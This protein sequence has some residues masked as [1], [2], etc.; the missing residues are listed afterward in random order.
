L[1]TYIP[2]S[3]LRASPSPPPGVPLAFPFFLF[4]F[5]LSTLQHITNY[6]LVYQLP[7][8]LRSFSKPTHSLYFTTHSFPS[9]HS[10]F[11]FSL[12]SPSSSELTEPALPPDPYYRLH[13]RPRP[14]Q[15]PSRPSRSECDRD[16]SLPEDSVRV[17]DKPGNPAIPTSSTTI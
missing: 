5:T 8:T 2:S 12:D 15:K 13:P 10:F 6:T 3:S 1:F 16:S 17:L 7:T 14:P 9:P 4:Y 11:I